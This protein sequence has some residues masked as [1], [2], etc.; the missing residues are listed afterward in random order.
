MR[1]ANRHWGASSGD[2]ILNAL[3]EGEEQKRLRGCII[4]CCATVRFAV[5]DEAAKDHCQSTAQHVW[6][7]APR[8]HCFGIWFAEASKEGAHAKGEHQMEEFGTSVHDESSCVAGVATHVGH[9]H[10][11]VKDSQSIHKAWREAQ[12]VRDHQ[13]AIVVSSLFSWISLGRFWLLCTSHST[14]QGHQHERDQKRIVCNEG[15]EAG[16]FFGLNLIESSCLEVHI[17]T[18][19]Q[20]QQQKAAQICFSAERHAIQKVN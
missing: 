1:S 14:A 5:V 18:S 17:S 9:C 7:E 8:I 3:W 13:E 20:R 11:H 16:G 2:A 19:A 15:S 4:H 10:A 6:R 12:D